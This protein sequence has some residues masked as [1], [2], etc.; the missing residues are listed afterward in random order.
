MASDGPPVCATPTTK[1]KS[2]ACSAWEKAPAPILVPFQRLIA[3]DRSDGHGAN[4]FIRAKSGAGDRGGC[5]RFASS[6]ARGR[7]FDP[8]R[9]HYRSTC[10]CA[11]LQP[12]DVAR[13][14]ST[15]RGFPLV[16]HC[17]PLSEGRDRRLIPGR[18]PR[19]AR[20]RHRTRRARSLS[21]PLR[22]SGPRTPPG[23]AAGHTRSPR[24]AGWLERGR[25]V[26]VDWELLDVRR[27]G[28]RAV[29]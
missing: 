17:W 29:A 6:G 3:S 9:A 23:T 28:E 10:K 2:A 25:G 12:G 22:S 14:R 27:L 4:P 24:P 11:L 21:H 18:H 15:R 7:W 26:V 13:S 5:G 16:G 1:S 8:S 20:P 19:L